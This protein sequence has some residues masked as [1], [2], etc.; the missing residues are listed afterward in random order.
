MADILLEKLSI[1][2]I[3]DFCSSKILHTLTGLFINYN[4]LPELSL[5][6]SSLGH[7]FVAVISKYFLIFTK[8]EINFVLSMT[9]YDECCNR[10]LPTEPETTTTTTT[11]EPTT[12]IVTTMSFT[13][14]GATNSNKTNYVGDG[15]CDDSYEACQEKRNFWGSITSEQVKNEPK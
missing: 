11:M 5:E 2:K 12:E 14:T 1:K 4:Y 9:V 15:Y 13:T 3:T 8:F 10:P 7:Y 6:L